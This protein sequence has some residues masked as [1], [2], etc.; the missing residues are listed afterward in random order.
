MTSSVPPTPPI[1]SAAQAVALLEPLFAGGGFGIIAVLHLDGERRL[2]G[3][4]QYPVA[5]D[6]SRLPTRA[7]LSDG[8]RLGAEGMVLAHRSADAGDGPGEAER[9]QTSDLA[10]VGRSLGIELHDR[11]VFGD[12]ACRSYRAMGLL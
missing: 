10:E 3:I 2:L 9:R 5:E 7:I 1:A 12:G 6:E 11:L 8:L 4:G